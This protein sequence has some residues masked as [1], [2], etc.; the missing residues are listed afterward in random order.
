M[1]KDRV[2]VITGAAG[3]IG[4]V[5]VRRFLANGDAVFAIDVNLEGLGA[6]DGIHRS[7]RRYASITADITEAASI[8]AITTA[9]REHFE[10]VN[11]LINCAGFYPVVPFEQM[12]LDDWQKVIAINLT[13]TFS[14]CH[15]LLP[16]MKAKGWGR[17]INFS[18]ASI[19]EGVAGQTHYVAAKAGVVGLSRS[20]AMEVGQYGIT[21][22][23]VAPGLTLTPP[24]LRDLPQELIAEQPKLRALK[25]D[26]QAD[27][28]AGAVFFLASPEADFMSGQLLNVDGGKIKH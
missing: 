12:Q 5:L 11:I 1:Q 14:M 19:F 20:L 3:G 2:V 13:G 10:E 27:D 23:C 15:S 26:E 8:Q 6:L 16:M 9:I 22:N 28:L 18:S 25:R 21:V 7:N 24:V 4:S 17:I